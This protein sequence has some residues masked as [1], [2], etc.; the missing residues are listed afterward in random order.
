[1][2]N[3]FKKE[4]LF[5][6]FKKGLTKTKDLLSEKFSEIFEIDKIVDLQT[7]EELEE[8]FILAD[9]GVETT[10]ALLEPFKAKILQ[11][12]TLTTRE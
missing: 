10:L 1:M 2:F 5:E 11:G 4:G 7:I 12:E 3:F 6:K 9:V 8:T